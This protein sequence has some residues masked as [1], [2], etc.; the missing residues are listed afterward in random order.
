MIVASGVLF[1]YGGSLLWGVLPRFNSAVSWEGHLSGAIAG[2]IVAWFARDRLAFGSSK[3]SRGEGSV[4]NET[5]P[6]I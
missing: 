2:V 1:F 5:P 3:S 4:L 6:V